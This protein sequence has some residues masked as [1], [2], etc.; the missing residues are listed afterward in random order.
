MKFLTPGQVADMFAI[1]L[2][3]VYAWRRHKTGPPAIRIGRHLRY[4]P[5]ALDRWVAGRAEESTA[6]GEALSDAP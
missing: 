1:P 5:R 6:K 3:T 2:K 4:D